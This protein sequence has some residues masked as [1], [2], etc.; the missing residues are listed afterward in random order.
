MRIDG[1]VMARAVLKDA[2]T[3]LVHPLTVRAVT[4][5]PTPA[6]ESYLSIKS[7]RA[8]DAGMTLDIVR[9]PEDTTE[10]AVIDAVCREGADAVIV[11]LPLPVH[12][13]E[14]R[15]LNAI[16][17]SLD[18]DVLSQAARNAFER[19]DKDA[20]LPPVVDAVREILR[21][22]ETTIPGSRAVVIGT[23]RLV[24]GPVAQW[25]KQEGA[26]VT[27]LDRTSSSEAFTSALAEA[28]IIVS[29]A[30]SPGIIRPEH[31]TPGKSVLIDAGVSESSG[32][33]VGDADPMCEAVAKAFTPVP[34]G[35]GPLAVACLFR[36]AALLTGRSLPSA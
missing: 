33:I 21:T 29:G 17:V 18:A 35:V 25:L 19:G 34:G 8:T 26:A 1:K 10:E 31:L 23:G 14:E 6:T 9:L 27:V 11:Q 12:I 16:P 36:N 15:I 30:G 5:C 24:G 4:V 20:L 2:R 32:A 28:D 13:P 7:A 3:Q 22:T